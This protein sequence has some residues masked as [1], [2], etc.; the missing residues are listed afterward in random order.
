MRQLIGHV[1]VDSGQILLTDP[2]YLDSWKDDDAFSVIEAG[3]LNGHHNE[4]PLDTYPYSYGGACGASC[5]R[6]HGAELEAGTGVCVS[7]GLG[8][9]LYPV[10]VEYTEMMGKRIKSVTIEFLEDELNE[11]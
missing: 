8:D 10:Y 5:S 7:S 9:G 6:N 4:E 2:C 1:G 11:G 3:R